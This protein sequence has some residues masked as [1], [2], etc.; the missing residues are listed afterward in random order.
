MSTEIVIF[1]QYYFPPNFLSQV[2]SGA[3]LR[4]TIYTLLI[5]LAIIYSIEDIFQNS[6]Y[7]HN[8]H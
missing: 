2:V 4:Q 1:H 6:H 3:N 7:I 8:V 5:K